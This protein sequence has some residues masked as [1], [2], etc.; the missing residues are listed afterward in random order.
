MLAK[1]MLLS[2]ARYPKTAIEVS[3]K[4]AKAQRG[5]TCG[6]EPI[7]RLVRV[8]ERASLCGFAPVLDILKKLGDPKNLAEYRGGNENQQTYS[9]KRTP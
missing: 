2:Q 5:V 1:N 8:N 7:S 3:R 6:A 4:D 9:M